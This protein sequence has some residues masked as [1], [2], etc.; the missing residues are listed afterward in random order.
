MLLTKQILQIL[1]HVHSLY[2]VS[3]PPTTLMDGIQGDY[4]GTNFNGSPARITAEELDRRALESPQFEITFSPVPGNPDSPVDLAVTFT[5][6]DSIKTYTTPVS[7]HVALLERGVP[8][9]GTVNGTVNVVRK[10]LLTGQERHLQ[11][12]GRTANQKQ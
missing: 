4:F 1:R 3:H 6:I 12:H 9:S 2:G 5:Y 11:E 10:L 7:L 8:N